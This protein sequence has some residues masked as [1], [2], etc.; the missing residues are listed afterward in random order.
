MN[1]KG[2]VEI[3]PSY[4]E[5]GQV[6]YKDQALYLYDGKE[7]HRLEDV[8]YTPVKL[9][10]AADGG[11]YLINNRDEAKFDKDNENWEM[12]MGFP[13][14]ADIERIVYEW[15]A[16]WGKFLINDYNQKQLYVL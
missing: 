13:P 6:Y 9:K 12:H 16:A 3:L 14:H 2:T 4:P 5:E 1:F 15:Y 11:L 7:W 8:A 10:K